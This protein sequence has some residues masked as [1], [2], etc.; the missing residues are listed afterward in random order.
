MKE[1][2]EKSLGEMGRKI[3][4]M[5]ESHK[6]KLDMSTGEILMGNRQDYMETKKREMDL[7]RERR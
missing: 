7:S 4:E 6:E 3:T 5:K 1:E 2:L